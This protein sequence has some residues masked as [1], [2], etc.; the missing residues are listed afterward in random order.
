M[1]QDDSAEN[2]LQASWPAPFP[3]SGRQAPARVL[4]LS[5]P[6]EPGMPVFPGDPAVQ[7][8]AAARLD[9]D[10]CRVSALHLN[11]HA[12]T[13]AD[14][15]A[16]V[17]EHGLCLDQLP[18][19]QLAGSALVIGCM[20]IGKDGVIPLDR[21]LDAGAAALLADFLIFRTG[22]ERRWGEEAY[23]DH[24]PVLS[25]DAV[26]WIAAQGK[27]G[28][29]LDTPGIDPAHDEGLALHK[30]LL[31]PGRT[32]ILENLAHLAALPQGEL[33]GLVAA[34][35]PVRDADGAPARVL[36]FL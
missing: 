35:L 21:I 16:H 6:I 3:A 31:A 19:S 24:Y 7:V 2:P 15:P 12:G 14:A 30:A 25:R 26:R 18:A 8:D 13:H 5:H 17:F 36:A 20:D 9:R 22:W 10:G 34:P 29:G 28:I 4:D 11:T 1:L 27:K 23:F 33:L 32:L